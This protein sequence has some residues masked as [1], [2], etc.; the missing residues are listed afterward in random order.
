MKWRHGE[1]VRTTCR[2][3]HNEETDVLAVFTKSESDGDKLE[4]N[5]M[6]WTCSMDG[7]AKN[8]N[9]I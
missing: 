7:G 4:E 9:N 1:S 5:E 3:F 8:G 2:E 6:N